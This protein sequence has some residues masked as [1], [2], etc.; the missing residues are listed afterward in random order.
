M[1]LGGERV[2]E[3]LNSFQLVS[4]LA[5]DE[6]YQLVIRWLHGSNIG[7]TPAVKTE[8]VRSLPQSSQANS[9]MMS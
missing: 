8:V 1:S 2:L 5:E 3:F 6:G 7:R 4:M 9:G